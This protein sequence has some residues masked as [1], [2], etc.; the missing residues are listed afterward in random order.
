MEKN[1]IFIHHSLTKDSGTVSWNAI[2]EYH[3]KV[4]KWKDIGYHAGVEL[5]NDRYQILMGRMWDQDAAAVK[6]QGANRWGLHVCVVGN[7]DEYPVPI[8]QWNTTRKLVK[9]WMKLYGISVNRVFGHKDYASYKSC[10]G[11]L[12]DLK[13]FKSQL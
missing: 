5:V 9:L 7:F 11:R 1:A 10:P 13:V 3:T 2:Y 12:F 6:E 8:E 4:N